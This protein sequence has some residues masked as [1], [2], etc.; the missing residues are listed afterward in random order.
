MSKNNTSTRVIVSAIFIPLILVACYL[1]GI[2]FLVFTSLIAL[3]SFY[4]F[5]KMNAEKKVMLNI[6]FGFLTI[7]VMLLNAYYIFT[8]YYTIALLFTTLIT[9]FE[10]F[11]NKGSAINNIAATLFGILYIGLLFSSLIAVREFY[12]YSDFLYEQGGFII[13]SIFITIWVCDSAAFFLGTAFGKHKL[14]PRVSPNKSWE[15]AVAGFIFSLIT[16]TALKFLLLDFLNWTDVVILGSIVG[17]V[18][19]IGDLIES[20]IKRDAGV[21]DSSALIP[22]HGGI[23]DRFDSLLYTS[24]FVY[25]YLANFTTL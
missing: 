19:Q 16:M 23:F 2:F 8:D 17:I 25:L 3:I 4:E 7:I 9:F 15:G 11:R 12:G 6:P 18:G 24:P 1:G 14:F 21:K 5:A 10:L 22:G 13:I 20:L